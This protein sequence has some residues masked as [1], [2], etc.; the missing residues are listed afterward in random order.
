MRNVEVV[1]KT[2]LAMNKDFTLLTRR[3]FIRLTGLTG[4]GLF[5]G[6]GFSQGSAPANLQ[7]N[8]FLTI[9]SNGE[10]TIMAKNPEIGQGV[11]TSLPMII[12]EELGADW[13]QIKVVQAPFKRVYGDQFAGGST[14]V[15]SNWEAIRR[16]GAA[17]REM[18]IEAAARKWVVPLN[19]CE[20]SS[21]RINHRPSGRIYSFGELAEAAS[22]LRA[23][24]NPP[25]KKSSEFRLLGS[26]VRGVDNL[27]IATGK[28]LYGS[29]ARPAG[30]LVAVVQRSPVFGG[31]VVEFDA[32][33]A[34][35]VKG[36]VDVFTVD[37]PNGDPREAVIGVAVVATDTWAAMKGRRALK[38]TWSNPEGNLISTKELQNIFRKNLETAG[39]IPLRNDGNFDE[40]FVKS[41]RTAE[42]LY[43][44][45]LLAHASME[46]MNYFAD[47]R[48][49]KVVLSGST[50]DP[51]TA[52]DNAMAITGLPAEAI[53]ITISRSGGGFGRRL[54]TDYSS[55]A[56]FISKKMGKPVQ[57]L[58]TREDDFTKDFYRPAGMYKLRGALD[59]NNRLVAWQ[60]QATTTSRYAYAK[61]TSSHHTTEVFP[62][63]FP[64][65]FVPNFKMEY[66]PVATPIP[67]GAWRAPGHNAT[68]FVDQCFIDEMAHL[69][70]K[71]PV[72]FRLE[73]LGEGDK[74]MPYQD[75]GGPFYSTARLKQVISI[76]A[77]KS[78]WNETPPGMFRGFAAHFMFGAYVAE[79]VT[80]SV[81]KDKKIKV[82]EVVCVIDCG[83]LVNLSGAEAQA[84]GGVLDG[85]SAAL[86]QEMIVEEG[87]ATASNFNSYRLLR[88]KDRPKVTVHFVKSDASPEG[89]GEMSLP[90]VAAALCNAVFAATGKRIRKLPVGSSIA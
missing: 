33:E 27:L 14:A 28:A 66:T 31:R 18:L 39:T 78:G 69:A 15:K 40:A 45:P 9:S 81:G 48:A 50:Q 35:K 24:S 58:W 30:A 23:P 46:P 1:E 84:M 37:Q 56:I 55:E 41:T 4:T 89:L 70:S 64:A 43:E 54:V 52:R 38:V 10:I 12:A 86:Y 77:E 61:A 88:M 16:A 8:A 11:K 72:A 21:S 65:G 6:I 59:E 76:A 34:L 13:K 71:D 73:L 26:R 22:K 17:A 42:A 36:V 63:G 74:L 80:V 90:P 87:K 49:D 25:L 2:V 5:F 20:A 62:D 32:A 85:L 53:E 75:H 19:E 57:V 83:V 29:D 68:A 47:V 79:V 82:D 60:L 44:V 7:P 51:E 3:S 67:T